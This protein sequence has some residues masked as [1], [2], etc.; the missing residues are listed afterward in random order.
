[1]CWVQLRRQPPCCL[2]PPSLR[3]LRMAKV[4]ARASVPEPPLKQPSCRHLWV[5]R[6]VAQD[7]LPQR[8]LESIQVLKALCGDLKHGPQQVQDVLDV[9]DLLTG[10]V[11][12]LA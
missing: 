8:L 2:T 5:A 6:V 7:M 4:G 10:S 9:R 3:G 12:F 1:M 11:A